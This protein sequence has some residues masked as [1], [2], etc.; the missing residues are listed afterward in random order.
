MVRHRRQ[1]HDRFAGEQD[2]ASSGA[3]PRG[4]ERSSSARKPHSPHRRDTAPPPALL[5]CPA[6][7]RAARRALARCARQDRCSDRAGGRRRRRMVDRSRRRR[8]ARSA[9][10]TLRLRARNRAADAANRAPPSHCRRRRM[11]AHRRAAAGLQSQSGRA[12]ALWR[13]RPALR[14]A[15]RGRETVATKGSATFQRSRSREKRR[16][17]PARPISASA[18]CI[19]CSRGT[20]SG[21]ALITPRIAG[22]SIRSS[23]TRSTMQACRGTRR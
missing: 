22:S 14:P 4:C 3:R 11:R 16:A 1:A 12:Q 8:A 20:G 5:A 6:P 15:S 17:K 13:R 9:R 2:R 21:R 18:R 19:C 23:S 7:W 10:R